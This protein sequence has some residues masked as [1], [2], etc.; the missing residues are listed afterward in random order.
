[1]GPRRFAWRQSQVVHLVSKFIVGA[2]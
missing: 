1:V 2:G